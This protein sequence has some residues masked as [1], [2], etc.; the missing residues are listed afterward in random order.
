[1]QG[2]VGFAC[3]VRM[4]VPGVEVANLSGVR[5]G[6]RT[7][8]GFPQPGWRLTGRLRELRLAGNSR[9]NHSRPEAMSDYLAR[10]VLATPI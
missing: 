2:T 4:R 10:R 3:L 7:V 5:M 8:V 9:L 6:R 1:M